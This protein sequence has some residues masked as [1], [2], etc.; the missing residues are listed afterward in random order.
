MEPLKHTYRYRPPP[1]HEESQRLYLETELAR[2]A[3]HLNE[4]LRKL[5]ELVD[6]ANGP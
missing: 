2:I 1:V 5:N 4:M 6:H 3:R